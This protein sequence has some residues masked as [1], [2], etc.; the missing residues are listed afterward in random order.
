MTSSTI[1]SKK[2]AGFSLFHFSAAADTMSADQ[3]KQASNYERFVTNNEM[4]VIGGQIT[5][6]GSVSSWAQ[7]AAEN[8][9]PLSITIMPIEQIL[10]PQYFPGIPA[11]ELQSKQSAMTTAVNRYCSWLQAQGVVAQCSAPGPDPPTPLGSIWGGFYQSDD[12]NKD[13]NVNPFT[14]ALACPAGFNQHQIGRVTAPESKCG[15]SQFVCLKDGLT[16]DPLQNYGGGYQV[17]DQGKNNLVNP[18]TG[19]TTCPAGYIAV[20]T[21]RISEPELKNSG[22][23]QFSCLNM[24][25]VP[26]YE[27][28]AGFY[29][30]SDTNSVD[31]I[32]NPF[33]SAPSC[34]PSY[35]AI[36]RG[37]TLAP[38]AKAG[39][40]QFVCIANNLINLF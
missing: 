27:S 16:S 13:N 11:S 9:M 32:T 17:N 19:A 1:D 2:S 24:N 38:E 14:L 29:Q 3:K 23:N 33:T 6:N 12:C 28:T 8:P 10:T 20:N 30:I 34:P 39:A 35:T 21:G 5:Q 7:T 37:R 40:A 31:R 26:T 36:Q 15:A 4:F 18:L 25:H 22:G